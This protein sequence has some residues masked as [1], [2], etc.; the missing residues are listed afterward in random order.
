[1][2]AEGHRMVAQG[3][4]QFE[5][6]IRTAGP[7]GFATTALP[8]KRGDHTNT[9]TSTSTSS[10]TSR[11]SSNGCATTTA[12]HTTIITS[13]NLKGGPTCC[14]NGRGCKIMGLPSVQ[15]Y[16]GIERWM[17][18]PHKAGPHRESSC[19]CPL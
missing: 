18:C 6:A 16:Q 9:T 3:W 14:F 19:V 17:Q 15:H 4:T 2:V 11:T 8:P 10:R 5:E 13:K 1:M 7:W 12:R